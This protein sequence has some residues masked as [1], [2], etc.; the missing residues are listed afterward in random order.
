M[1]YKNRKFLITGGTGSLGKALIKR[2]T[3]EGA[4]ISVYSRDEGKQAFLRQDFPNVKTYIGC[5]RD[6]ERLTEIFTLVEP[7]YVIHAGA[8]KR[9]DDGES[10]ESEF[11]KTNVNGSRN[12]AK[13]AIDNY[14]EKCILVSTDK[15]CLPVNNY[16]KGKSLAEGIFTSENGKQDGTILSSVRYGNVIASRGSAIPL[17][18]D[19]INQDK[20]IQITSTEMTRF[21]FTLDDAVDTVLH[22]LDN[23]QGGEVFIPQISS[24]TL[25]ALVNA[26]S[27]IAGKTAKT[28]ISGLRPGEKLHEDMLEKTELPRTYKVPGANLLQVRPC[29]IDNDEYQDFEKYNGP[30]F[31]SE[32]WV[33]DEHESLVKLIETGLKC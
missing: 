16:G 22:A 17:F 25:P 6:Y 30:H 12:V 23:A 2:L 11:T 13:A 20:T 7:D 32:L 8:L 27:T 4:I 28:I 31:N 15:A 3:K 10:N 5:V 24:Y 21:F 18:L 19:L 14:V 29:N 1:S 9:I 33:K 26:V